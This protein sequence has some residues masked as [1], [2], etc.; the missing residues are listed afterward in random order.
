M[1][2]VYDLYKR[3][4]AGADAELYFFWLSGAEAYDVLPP[5]FI[6]AG[7]LNEQRKL[8]PP[9]RFK[10]MHMNEWGSADA[11]LAR[12]VRMLA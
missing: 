9:N 8:L 3:G 6:R 7:Y 1:R 10:R 4:L 11:S 5:G 2:R 12:T